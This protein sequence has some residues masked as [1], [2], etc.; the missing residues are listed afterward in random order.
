MDDCSSSFATHL[1]R[2][3]ACA[4]ALCLLGLSVAFFVRG[5]PVSQPRPGLTNVFHVLLTRD[6]IPALALML[7]AVLALFLVLRRSGRGPGEDDFVPRS[8]G[9][10]P[11]VLLCLG[12]IVATSLGA[13][14]VTLNF[15]LS[16]DEYLARFQATLFASG[17]VTA[18]VPASWQP[19][20]QALAPGTLPLDRVSRVWVSNYLPVWAAVLTPFQLMRVPWLASPLLAAG[21]LALLP[22]IRANVDPAWRWNPWIAALILATSCQFLVNAM[23][24]YAMTAHLFFNL[25]W[26]WLF[27][28]SGRKGFW[29]AGWVGFLAIGLH[30]PVVHLAFAFP[31]LFRLVRQRDW[32]WCC[33]FLALYAAALVCYSYWLHWGT[34]SALT[35][36]RNA[37]ETSYL[38]HQASQAFRL[39]TL[40]S[41]LIQ[42]ESLAVAIAWAAPLGLI[43]FIFALN[44]WDRWPPL[45]RDLFSSFILTLAVY[46]FFKSDQ[47]HG[48]GYRYYHGVLG[49]FVIIAAMGFEFLRDSVSRPVLIRALWVNAGL[50]LFFFL[51]LR[52]YQVETF[53]AP[54]ARAEAL[55]GSVPDRYVLLDAKD[56]WYGGDLIRNDPFFQKGPLVFLAKRLTVAERARLLQNYRVRTMNSADFKGL[57]LPGSPVAK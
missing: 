37:A 41:V 22:A 36:P 55:L 40:V 7:G 54:F 20:G 30:Q 43:L 32:G 52:A 5:L 34:V 15:P 38:V 2:T 12:V 39:P 50:L 1:R 4:S 49:N 45:A 33:Y 51:P 18:P 23:T 3:V 57:H 27:T 46:F 9:W 10:G 31:F 53:V 44:Y 16:L 24:L 19:W 6:E 17:R 11:W 8:V 25:L 29:L 28:L 42:L 26:L 47:G 35:G 56:I 13:F 48:W 21:S 14:F